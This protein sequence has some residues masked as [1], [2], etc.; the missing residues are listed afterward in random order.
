METELAKAYE[1]QEVE[2][3]IYDFWMKGNWF[4]AEPD[5]EKKP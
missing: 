4:H 3:R 2:K 1:P 5:P